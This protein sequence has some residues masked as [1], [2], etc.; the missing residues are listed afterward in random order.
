MSVNNPKKIS[1]TA[2][3]TNF[4]W[5]YSRKNAGYISYFDKNKKLNTNTVFYVFGDE[6]Y[7]GSLYFLKSKGYTFA[8]TEAYKRK[9]NNLIKPDFVINLSD[10]L[11]LSKNIKQ[12]LNLRLQKEINGKKIYESIER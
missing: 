2:T 8:N 5:R 3:I 9:K 11:P 12:E 7:N 6:T 4:I 1:Q 10:S